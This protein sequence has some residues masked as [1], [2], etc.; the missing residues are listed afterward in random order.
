MLCALVT[1]PFWGEDGA[2]VAL[3]EQV[4]EWTS[5]RLVRRIPNTGWEPQE[6]ERWLRDT[7]YS[8]V[9]GF[10]RWLHR[11]TGSPWMDLSWE[12]EQ[13]GDLP[14]ERELVDYMTEQWPKTEA[15]FEEIHE[16]AK[17]LEADPGLLRDIV[18][19]IEERRAQLALPMPEYMDDLDK[20]IIEY[21]QINGQAS[22]ATIAR[23]V[24]VSEEMVTLRINALKED[25]TLVL[26]KTLMEVF[27]DNNDGRTRIRI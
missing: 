17:K 16:L 18:G 22:Y 23:R 11:E 7:E 10:A 1:C 4:A 15:F 5:M 14:W 26:G 21:V 9:A 2:M 19:R 12:D 24:G 27:S 8:V 25:G 6:L 20:R 13:M 3:R